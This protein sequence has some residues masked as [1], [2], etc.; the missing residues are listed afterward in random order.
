MLLPSWIFLAAACAA[1]EA[2]ESPPEF[3]E[4]GTGVG[5][6]TPD[7]PGIVGIED[8]VEAR[9][10]TDVAGLVRVR[11]PFPFLEDGA[12][13]NDTERRLPPQ[14]RGYYRE[15]TVTTP[16]VTGRGARRLVVGAGGE[17]FYWR[18]ERVEFLALH[19]APSPGTSAR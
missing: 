2:P 13:F 5:Y 8:P 19:V 4:G 16:G 15:Y 3:E 12:I 11:G 9:L 6:E 14:A 18:P 17:L 1:C 10:V 7:M